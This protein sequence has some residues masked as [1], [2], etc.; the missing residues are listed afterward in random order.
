MNKPER[1][2]DQD[3]VVPP[4][5]VE[6]EQAVLGGLMLKPEAMSELADWLPPEAFWQRNHQLIFSAIVDLVGKGEPCDAV[7]LGEFFEAQGI[8]QLV[9]GARYVIELANA[10]PSAAN[11]AAYA[12]IV[13]EK[14]KLRRAMDAGAKLTEAA[15]AR[16]AR[17][18]D[19]VAACMGDLAM[20]AHESRLGGPVSGKTAIREWY[21]DLAARYESEEELSGVETPWKGV[22]ELTLGWQPGQLYVIAGRSNMGKSLLGF[23]SAGYAACRGQRVGIWSIE[24]SRRQFVQRMVSSVQHIPH[25]HLRRPKLLSQEEWAQISAALTRL[26]DAP[27]VVDD[28]A[29]LTAAQIVARAKREHMRSPFKKIL[30]DHLHDVRLPGKESKVDEVGQAA[31]EFK[32]LAKALNIP[33]LLIA[34]LNRA[35]EARTDR[36][37]TLTDLRASGE[38]EQIADAVLFV[39][40]EDYYNPKTHL[41]GVLEVIVG[42]GRDLPTGDT[43]YLESHFDEMRAEDWTGPLPEKP[44]SESKAKS[45]RGFG[46]NVG[47]DK[48][49]KDD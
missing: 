41:K 45:T 20:I 14:W 22:N 36:R 47:A 37:P 30:I 19:L 26:S 27:F 16:G 2:R 8:A 32:G 15:R 44:A 31:R 33:V 23:Q 18:Q 42:K 4:H 46:G 35:N 39:H 3:L 11:I 48:A 25:A 43:T 29:G 10:T 21:Q 38:I 5:S 7:T 17:A 40:R 1:I 49:G 12:E 34:Q 9:G 13:V 6:A 24:M 28:Q